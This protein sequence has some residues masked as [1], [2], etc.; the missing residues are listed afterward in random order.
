MSRFTVSIKGKVHPKIQIQSLAPCPPADG[1]T[2]EVSE[3]ANKFAVFSK[4]NE[5]DGDLFSI[6][7]KQPPKKHLSPSF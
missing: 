4:N 6:L 3:S 5:G 2:A 7:K 1:N